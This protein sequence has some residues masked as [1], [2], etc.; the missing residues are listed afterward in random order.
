MISINQTIIEELPRLDEEGN[1]CGAFIE[2]YPGLNLRPL[3]SSIYYYNEII[4][5]KEEKE[6][7]KGQKDS[8]SP[9]S[10]PGNK[11]G[12]CGD[13][14]MDELLDSI[15]KG[16]LNDWHSGWEEL[17][18]SMGK[19]QSD[20]LRK[21]IQEKI[22]RI[23]EETIK[24]RGHIPGHLENAIKSNF[25]NKPPII[26]W[27]TLFNR[28]IGSTLT[29]DI[30][31]TRKRPNFRFEDA[32]S[33][34]YKNKIKIIVGCDTSGSVSESELK[35]FF[36]QIRHMWKTGSKIDICLWDA[37]ADKPYEYKGEYVYKRTRAGGTR[38]SSFIEYV[39]ANKNKNNWT[40]AINLTDGFIEEHPIACR[41]PMLWVITKEGS[42]NFKHNCKKIKMN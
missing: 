39:N 13:P 15:E 23:G 6:N 28:F 1:K 42:T 10:Q 2:D 24:S 7:T 3:E 30:Y 38:A 14:N 19:Q 35:E 33:N 26:S 41:L 27:K 11:D 8:K 17:K 21:D 36:G 9:S 22:K 5:A 25:G 29:T 16:E 31:Q 32:P 40:C 4:K 18:N 34:R 12:S 20:L 37:E